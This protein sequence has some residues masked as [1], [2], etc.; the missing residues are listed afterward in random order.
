[1]EVRLL[2]PL[3]ATG[4]KGGATLGG[5]KQRA[6]LALLA[7]ASGRVVTTDA[8]VDSLWGEQAAAG[9]RRT[10]QVYVSLLR[11]ALDQAE[12]GAASR[13]R[14]EGSGYLLELDP[15]AV[16]LTRFERLTQQ[17]RD[18][19]T[20]GD[21]GQALR[22][23][24]QALALWRGPA[25]AEFAYESWAQPAIGRL[26]EAHAV[27]L[28]DRG[29]ALLQLGRHAEL[30]GDLEAL[31]RQH[32][33]RERLRG[34]LILALYR[35]GRQA[36]ALTAY[37]SARDVLVEQLGVDPSP[38]L[39]ALHRQV[40]TQDAVL[41][42][43][44]RT[45]SRT[46]TSTLPAPPTPL[47]GREGEVAELTGLVVDDDVRLV[48]LT[49]PGGAGKTRLSIEVGVLTRDR[50]PDGVYWVPLADLRDADRVL[51]GI[52]G[53]LDAAEQPGVSHVDVICD[54]LAGKRALVVIDNAEHLLPGL[55][56]DL[57]SLLS[58]CQ[59]VS[60]LVS[61]RERLR[62]RGEN[63]YPVA[64]L[65]LDD[66][67]RLFVA[68]ASESGVD[69][70]E[71]DDVPELCD[72]LDRLPLAIELAAA[73]TSLFTPIQLLEHLRQ[74][75]DLLRGGRDIETRQQTLHATIDW[76]HELLD[77]G[78]QLLFARL[79]VFAG[80][81]TL[82][83][84]EEVCDG[85]LDTLASLVDK[86]LVRR[87]GERFGMLETIREYAFER[88]E[89]SSQVEALRDRHAAW[90]LALAE[91]AE[92]ELH[93]VRAASWFDRLEAEHANLRMA[94]GRMLA[95]TDADAALRLTGA[96]WT[97]WQERGYWSEGRR[98]LEAALTIA[99]DTKPESCV[100]SQWGAAVLALSQGDNDTAASHSGALLSL[101]REHRMIRA[102][103]IALQL[104][105]I[106]ASRLADHRRAAELYERALPIAYEAADQ[107]LVWIILN[108]L[109]DAALNEGD[110]KL[111]VSFFERSLAVG[112]APGEQVMRA[113]VLTNLGAATLALGD[114]ER[115]R[116]YF[117]EGL[118]AATEVGLRDVL[119]YGLLGL[120][121]ASTDAD[122]M[123][124]A[125]L[126]GSVD[127]ATD[128]LEAKIQGFELR[129]YAEAVDTLRTSLGEQT[130]AAAYAEGRTLT[131]E[132][133]VTHT[134]AS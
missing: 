46:G 113:R 8:L 117:R 24:D 44:A 99:A 132:H 70:H 89:A 83:A 64:P 109:G 106:V 51:S 75:P 22:L 110:F 17:A 116:A 31:T 114:R 78:E 102:E 38:Q 23:F 41:A 105:A 55:A 120:A 48:T 128:E 68:R 61:S 91:R 122:P 18:R 112:Q 84:G 118:T 16:D 76:S 42:A 39:Q 11:K 36:D 50:F 129:M 27:C 86:S 13:L 125:R 29:D 5:P 123:L 43:P 10:L 97:F 20:D 121:S 34:Q 107:F 57:A 63:V 67:V 94:L 49:G 62:I 7:L 80:G 119:L 96:I 12:S 98:W 73:R 103:A 52:A 32:P 131:L 58:R 133:A 19:L 71:D 26:D 126:L 66:A 69:L 79:A 6:V 33:L 21:A 130:W 115:A 25:L 28:E 88:L 74:R 60:W 37:Q 47:V 35:S 85:D 2:G 87:S 127:N 124:A 92:P 111:A 95:Q 56:M 81:W 108:N 1:M 4:P 101:A 65:I 104:L 93:A 90:Y 40:L 15:D 53:A 59:S 45:S 82:E 54:R 100:D 72:R 30:V 14:L 3:Q 9:G 134:L 77:D